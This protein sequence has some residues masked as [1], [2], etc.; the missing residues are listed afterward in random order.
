MDPEDDDA[1][2]RRLRSDSEGSPEGTPRIAEGRI[3]DAQLVLPFARPEAPRRRG[4]S[5][6]A[7]HGVSG[8]A[9]ASSRQVRQLPGL[10]G[11]LLLSKPESSACRMLGALRFRRVVP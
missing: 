4:I 5:P 10:D 1:P 3:A 11:S 6:L 8:P 2:G 9:G 7:A